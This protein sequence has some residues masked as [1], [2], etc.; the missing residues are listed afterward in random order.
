MSQ[1]FTLSSIFA[2]NYYFVINFNKTF[3]PDSVFAEMFYYF[4]FLT[5]TQFPEKKKW[6][7]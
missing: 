4:P 5:N 1:N 3:S 7:T 6:M 2:F